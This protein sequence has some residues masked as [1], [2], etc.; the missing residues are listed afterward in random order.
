[1]S[2]IRRRRYADRFIFHL[3]LPRGSVQFSSAFFQDIIGEMIKQN[4]FRQGN[5]LKA[6]QTIH[7]PVCEFM[8][9]RYS[10]ASYQAAITNHGTSANIYMISQAIQCYSSVVTVFSDI[11][12]LLGL[13]RIILEAETWSNP[14]QVILKN[15][16]WVS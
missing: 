3:R 4:T 5:A 10:N 15:S 16:I 1:M 12:Y 14:F 6:I 13:K 2:L 9:C 7:R 11:G 8:Y